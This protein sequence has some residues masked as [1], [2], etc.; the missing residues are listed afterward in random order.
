MPTI[1]PEKGV[2]RG[3]LYLPQNALSRLKDNPMP[4]QHENDVAPGFSH[5]PPDMV[6]QNHSWS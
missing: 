6:A 2:A 1:L 5:F 3:F 4:F